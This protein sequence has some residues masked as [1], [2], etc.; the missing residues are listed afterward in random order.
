MLRLCFA[1]L[2]VFSV[3]SA[4]ASQPINILTSI[5]PLQLIAAQIAGSEANTKVLLPPGASPHSFSLRPSDS[6]NI[7]NADLLYWIGPDM[8]NFLLPL[9]ERRRSKSI[10]LQ[11]LPAMHLLHY[12]SEHQHDNHR[13]HDHHH[14]PGAVDTHLW[15]SL[16]NAKVFAQQVAEDLTQLAPANA[17]LYQQRLLEFEQQLNQ[18]DGQLEE[19]LTPLKLANYFVFH[20]AFNYLEHDYGLERGGVFAI[21]PEVQPGARHVQQMRQQLELAG[22]ACIFTEP[23]APPRLAISLAK[24]L[25]VRLQE[26]DPLGLEADSYNALMLNIANNIFDCFKQVAQP[27]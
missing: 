17:E 23:P 8:E 11:N 27:K 15:L 6:R 24:D 16:H 18:L 12:N 21:N 20:E 1:L 5:K 19:I 22:P 25:P 9:I 13:E 3:L 2:T 14:L 7:A 4:Q 10:A 26:L